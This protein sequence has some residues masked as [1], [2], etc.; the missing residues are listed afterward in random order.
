MS[1]FAH[2]QFLGT[3][4]RSVSAGGFEVDLRVATLPP[5]AVEEH[6]HEVAHFILP[7]ADG[8][9]S[10]ARDPLINRTVFGAGSAIYNPPG[11]VHRDC[12]DVAGGLFCSVSVP[13]GMPGRFDHPIVLRGGVEVAMRRLVGLCLSAREGDH[14]L[15]EDLSLLLTTAVATGHEQSRHTPDWLMTA[16]EIVGDQATTQGLEIRDIAA[17]LG[18]HPVHLARAWRRYFEQSPGEAIRYRRADL[19]AAQIAKG[20][21]L[22]EVAANAGYA[23]QSHMTREY[24]HVFGVTPGTFRAAVA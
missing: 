7:L 5:D 19:A 2:G 17:Q 15:V 8:Y 4:N 21:H 23:D 20:L 24:V 16:V 13:A 3:R 1:Q 18:V 6:S 11:V 9:R 12:F 14:L 10:L 22:A